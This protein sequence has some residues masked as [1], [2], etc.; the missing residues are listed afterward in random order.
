MDAFASG[1]TSSCPP[2]H[3]WALSLAFHMLSAACTC[4][5]RSARQHAESYLF[6]SWKSNLCFCVNVGNGLVLGFV[7]KYP[8]EPVIK[9]CPLSVQKLLEW[10]F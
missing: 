5:S 1:K 8:V 7:T 4:A 6:C 10:C 2:S 9:S 3:V